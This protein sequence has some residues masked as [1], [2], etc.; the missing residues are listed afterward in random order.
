MSAA[1]YAVAPSH[2]YSLRHVTLTDYIG[3]ALLITAEEV[4]IH[5][6]GIY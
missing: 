5:M 2:L 1:A 4:Y 6:L 3:L